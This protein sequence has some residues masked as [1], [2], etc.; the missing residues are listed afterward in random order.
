MPTDHLITYPQPLDIFSPGDLFTPTIR[1]TATYDTELRRYV[2]A[3]VAFEHSLQA[4]SSTAIRG[5]PIHRRISN[6]ERELLREAN[7]AL[8]TRGPVKT[9]FRGTAGRK[10]SAHHAVHPSDDQ[11]ENAAIIFHLASVIRDA[12]VRAIERCFSIT[13]KQAQRWVRLARRKG[14]LDR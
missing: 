7:P 4:V 13:Y 9:Y 5:V 1:A 11:L 12:P 14:I 10:V 8:L 6:V 2:N 3:S